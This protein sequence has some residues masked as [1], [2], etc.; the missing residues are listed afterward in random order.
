MSMH[1]EIDEEYDRKRCNLEKARALKALAIELEAPQHVLDRIDKLKRE[2][3]ADL[4]YVEGPLSGFKD[5]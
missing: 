3:S 4:G 5:W 2:A 1:S